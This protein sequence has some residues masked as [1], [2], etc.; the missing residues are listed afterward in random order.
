MRRQIFGGIRMMR[1]LALAAAATATVG[2]SA[3]TH[4]AARHGAEA[5]IGT[6]TGTDAGASRSAA[7][8]PVSCGQQYRAWSHGE[9][10]GL[11][12]ILDAVTSATTTRDGKV[13]AAKLKQAG[14]A[15]T[16]AAHHPI[17]ACADPRGY[18]TVL[19]MHVNAA[20]TGKG[21]AS[22]VRAAIQDIRSIHHELI[23]EVKQ[24]AQ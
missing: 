16:K 4:G 3:C 5:G 2:L 17:P 24:T 14:P 22:A 8:V 13:L 6:G 11:M 23:A 19:L 1:R 12:K 15:V 9:G 7:I 21:S 18:W 10:K 20:A